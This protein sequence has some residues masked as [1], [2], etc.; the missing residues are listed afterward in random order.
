MEQHWTKLEELITKYKN[1]DSPKTL[2][3]INFERRAYNSVIRANNDKLE[4][5]VGK[6]LA[7]KYGFKIIETFNFKINY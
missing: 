5:T 6:L 4:S 2:E 1:D 3:K 7:K